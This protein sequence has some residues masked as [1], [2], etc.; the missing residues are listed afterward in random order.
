VAK[1]SPVGGNAVS[2]T[3]IKCAQRSSSGVRLQTK[4]VDTACVRIPDYINNLGTSVRKLSALDLAFF[5]AESEGSPKHV[6][7][8]MLFRKPTGNTRNF[9]RRLIDELRRHDQP[10]E[11]FNLVIHFT[12]LTGP[13]WQP[14]PD[15]DIDQHVFYHRPRKSSTWNEVKELVSSLHEPVMDRSRPLWEYHLI[16][17]IEGGR[18]AVYIRIHHA[19]ADGMTMTSWLQKTLSGAPDDM[20]LRPVWT[21]PPPRSRRKG[22]NRKS[23]AGGLR[24]L[25]SQSMSQILTAGGIAKLATQQVLERTG[26]TRR[27]VSLQFNTTHK[28][29]LTGSATAGRRIATACLG[30]DD[31]KS[32]CA[33]TRTTLNH[34]ALGCIDGALHR[35]LHE[36]GYPVDHPLTIQM[37]VNLR[38]DGKDRSGNMVGVAL[39]ELGDPG[40]DPIRRLQDIGHSLHKVRNQVDSVPGDAMQ[41]YT[42]ISALTAELID[43]LHLSDHIPATGHTLVSNVPGPQQTLY[44]K[45]ARL[46][47]NYP[48]SILVPGLRMNITLFSCS[49][50]LN[51]GIVATKDLE[52]LDLLGSCI[53]SEFE[54]IRQAVDGANKRKDA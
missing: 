20:T 26:I 8:L 29:P 2:V 24:D 40:S 33:A 38:K 34:L 19:Y 7:G 21:M 51:F 30:M 15:F 37:P 52:Q 14:A 22:V 48:I 11:P 49:G 39:V 18:F 32:V 43:K 9:G 17:G 3:Q 53:E 23:L 31:V 47:Q 36:T 41:Q 54:I 12:G 42:V 10:T 27:A 1:L 5:L 44:L 16:D 45:G 4:A 28:T 6:A 50:I 35:Y 25:G 46:E 13:H